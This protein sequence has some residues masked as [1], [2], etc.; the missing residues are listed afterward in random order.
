MNK[1]T[2]RWLLIGLLALTACSVGSAAGYKGASGDWSVACSVD[3]ESRTKKFVIQYVGDTEQS[4]EV[5]Y[6]FTGSG[7]FDEKGT[8]VMEG[9]SLKI[10]GQS[11]L[12][13]P[14]AEEDG[15]RLTI[16]WNGR[17]ETIPVER[18]IKPK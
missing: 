8:A 11:T 14:A 13:G 3:P 15:F 2:I 7:N 5:S 1:H 18:F 9:D 4:T 6:A 10:A 16:R 12:A 17:E